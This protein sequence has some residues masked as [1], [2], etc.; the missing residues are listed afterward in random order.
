MKLKRSNDQ[1][2]LHNLKGE[3]RFLITLRPEFKKGCDSLLDSIERCTPGREE[4]MHNKIKNII[5]YEH[6]KIRN[7]I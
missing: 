3:L 6:E 7:E 1:I 4:E 5:H 2:K